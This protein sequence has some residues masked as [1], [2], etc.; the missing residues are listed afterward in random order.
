MKKLNLPEEGQHLEM[1][2]F[3]MPSIQEAPKPM[4]PS[5]VMLDKGLLPSKGRFYEND[6]Y[7][8]KWGVLDIKNLNK[9]TANNLD[10]VVNSV[11]SNCISGVK[12]NDIVITDKMFLLIYTRFFTYNNKP[13]SIQVE[14]PI[15]GNAEKRMFTS[16]DIDVIQISDDF[17]TDIEL[18]SG[19][20]LTLKAPTIGNELEANR[21]MNNPQIIESLDKDM[22][23]VGAWIKSKNGNDMSM[24]NSYTYLSH[25]ISQEDFT[26]LINY[27]MN[28]YYFGCKGL[29]K[30]DCSCGSENKVAIPFDNQFFAPKM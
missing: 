15:C 5:M 10:G 4:N 13:I 6:I 21:L 18:P 19:T 9:M 14:C 16:K 17:D 3:Q 12:L 25:E 29:M 11:L 26:S 7:I 22:L 27:L 20:I 28:T 23:M 2:G 30:Y 24:F 1:G 8:K